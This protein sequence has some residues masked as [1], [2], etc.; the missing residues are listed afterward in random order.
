MS[1]FS[2]VWIHERILSVIARH[3]VPKQSRIRDGLCLRLP[4]FA[5]NDNKEFALTDSG[6]AKPVLTPEL[7]SLLSQACV[8][9]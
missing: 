4:R 6:R 3:G 9:A 1:L 7:S 5:R 2:S 8:P